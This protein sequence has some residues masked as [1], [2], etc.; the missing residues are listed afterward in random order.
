MSENERVDEPQIAGDREDFRSGLVEL[1]N[2]HSMENRS[3]TPDWILRNFLCD[4]L[5]AFDKATKQRTEFY[6]P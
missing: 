4:S 3:D 1:I 2:R 5:R 6:K